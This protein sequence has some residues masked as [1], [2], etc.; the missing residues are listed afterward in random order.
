LNLSF[1]CSPKLYVVS[2]S[3]HGNRAKFRGIDL[4]RR[5][6]TNTEENPKMKTLK[7]RNAILALASGAMILS[8]A[9]CAT[10]DSNTTAGTD[11][12]PSR[13]VATD[14]RVIE[15]G[16]RT[17][18]DNGWK[19]NDPHL[20]K[21]W[22]ASGFDFNNYD[23]LYIAPT[24]ST[25]KLH[26]PDE[27]NPQQIA[28]ENLVI[29]LERSLRARN[30]FANIATRESDIKPGARVLKLEN[31]II[32]YAKG[33]GAGRYFAGVFGGGQPV[34]R[35]SGKMT[36]GDKTVFTFEAKRS[37][38]SAG[39]RLV[40]VWMT[41]VDIQTEDIRSMTLDLSDFIAAI[42]GKYQARN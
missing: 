21:C 6:L 24:L 36:D 26:G 27:E 22:I 9:G 7:Y 14:G 33:G 40:G 15:I 12:F 23:T 3:L 30:I 38:T 2:E 18:A 8:L 4:F 1:F 16:R 13:Y 41:D 39:A 29:E 19:F 11:H 20:D 25:A 31:T 10:T 32:E 35:I 17:A 37:G 28:K 34:L 42:A 5:D